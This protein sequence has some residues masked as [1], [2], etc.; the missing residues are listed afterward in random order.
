MPS[1][2]G[3]T[4]AGLCGFMLAQ[5]HVNI[6]RWGWFLVGSVVIANLADLDFLPGMLL[7]DLRTFHHQASHSLTAVVIVSLLISGLTKGCGLNR[8]AL[9]IWGGVLY[10]SHIVLDLLVNDPSPPFGVQFLWPF[11]ETYFISPITP[12]ASF[13]YFNPTI[14][15]LTSLLSVHNL[16]TII[17]ETVLMTPL[18]GLAWYVGRYSSGRHFK[19]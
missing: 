17:W 7:G 12:F 19:R 4:L 14:G 18:V 9:G 3:H 13:D 6:H 1:P 8:V 15:I 2:V 11:S 16:N 10:L 5:N